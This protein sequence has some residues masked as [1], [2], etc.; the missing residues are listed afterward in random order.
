MG[1]NEIDTVRANC[2]T[3]RQEQFAEQDEI[4]SPPN[5]HHPFFDHVITSNYAR[6]VST[7]VN[8]S[9]RLPNT[10]FTLPNPTIRAIIGRAVPR[11][12]AEARRCLFAT[13]QKF[14][15]AEQAFQSTRT[16]YREAGTSLSL[17]EGRLFANGANN[18]GQCGVGSE[19]AEI[20]GPRLVRLP[21][22]TQVWPR[23]GIWFAQTIRGLY[24]WGNEPKVAGITCD[25][26]CMYRPVRVSITGDVTDII[27][28]GPHDGTAMP[29]CLFQTSSGWS[30]CG[31]WWI[32]ND[33]QSHTVIPTPTP[34]EGG[35]AVIH[36][37][38]PPHR[39]FA[40]TDTGHLLI[41]WI[42]GPMDVAPLPA[43]ANVVLP[44]V[45]RDGAKEGS[46]VLHHGA[47]STLIH[48]PV[49][50]RCLVLPTHITPV[51]TSPGQMSTYPQELM[52]P[53]DGV[54]VYGWASAV[55]SDNRLTVSDGHTVSDVLISVPGVD[56][57][58]IV[59]IPQE[60]RDHIGVLATD[61]RW[62]V[63]IQAPSAAG[64]QSTAVDWMPIENPDDISHLACPEQPLRINLTK[65]VKG[66][67]LPPPPVTITDRIR[68]WWMKY[69]E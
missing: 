19:Q 13:C 60:Q 49:H 35:H 34:V 67:P 3:E 21:P 23:N 24:V 6:K 29:M 61:G 44:D 38:L 15:M 42:T 11:R 5:V 31:I 66:P 50:R 69:T 52:F 33:T 28:P 18:V 27:I 58:A 14:Y 37:E 41:G 45:V 17:Y 48:D 53:V 20:A 8:I 47:S 54:A 43:L 56:V 1:R 62:F 63:S 4:D 57:A 2:R 26:P 22:T 16:V 12:P 7:T 39:I 30:V 68:R 64:I 40:W 32:G 36:W 55:L 10:I 59:V 65:P 51:V 25:K 9:G 46:V